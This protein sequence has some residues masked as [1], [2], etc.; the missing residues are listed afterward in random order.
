MRELTINFIGAGSLGK[1]LAKLIVVNKTGRI[2]G[3]CN[4]TMENSENAVRFIGQGMPYSSIHT[5]PSSDITFITVSDDRIK[6]VC[7]VLSQSENFNPDSTVIHC[8][9]LLTSDV[10][11][12]A[13]KKGANTSS[14]HPNRSFANPEISVQE[15]KGTYCAVEGD[16]AGEIMAANIFLNIGAKIIHIKKYK[17][18]IYHASAVIA[19]N[20]L[21]ALASTAINCLR[22][23][24]VNDE[25]SI[26]IILNMMQG[27][28]K[29]LI[30]IRSPEKSLT[31]PI[32]RGD[33]QT[34]KA[35]LASF[36]NEF[37]KNLYATLGE[38][39]LELT[40]HSQEKKKILKDAFLHW[41]QAG[42]F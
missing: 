17:K 3:V 14:V 11:L 33:V 24:D 38:A 41:Q 42:P 7:D 19:S 4:S 37:L 20:Y 32:K 1:T 35:H 2:L 23:A 13:K 29:N 22:S 39:T 30:S 28:L 25:N 21:V 9:G 8:S 16:D 31:G 34:I 6:D 26:D 27:T 12:S 5:L 36:E 40:S 18:A 15:F 10:L